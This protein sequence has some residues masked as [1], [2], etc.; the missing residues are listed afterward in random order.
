MLQTN[1]GAEYDFAQGHVDAALHGF[2]RD[3]S[4]K[5]FRPLPWIAVA[6]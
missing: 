1:T 2:E 3:E 5:W 6:L 4:L